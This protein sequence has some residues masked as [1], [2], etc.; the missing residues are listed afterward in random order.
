MTDWELIQAYV[1]HRSEEAFTQLVQRY[2]DLVS[3]L[4]ISP[5]N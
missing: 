1:Q 3:E 2:V 4:L 5:R